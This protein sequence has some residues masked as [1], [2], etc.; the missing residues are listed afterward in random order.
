MHV[1]TIREAR[2][3]L[4]KWAFKYTSCGAYVQF[5]SDGVVVGSIVEGVEG[6][7][8][9]IRLRWPFTVEQYTAA[10]DKTEKCAQEIWD[11][12]HGC[13]GCDGLVWGADKPIPDEWECGATQ[14][15]PDCPD[16]NGQGIV[17]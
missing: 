9:P 16:C 14:V 12:T 1:D 4:K 6:S 15:N 3:M 13:P 10:L 11:R 5:E 7:T 8:P 17:I 2:G